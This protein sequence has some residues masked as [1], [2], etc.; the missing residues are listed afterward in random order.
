MSP[1]IALIGFGEAGRTFAAAGEWRAT[2]RVFDIKTLD[3]ATAPAMRA[4]YAAHGVIGCETLAQALDGADIVLSLV[5]ADQAAPAAQAAAR[6]IPPGALFCDL[7][8]VSPGTKTRNA[9]VLEAAGGRYV[10]VAVMSPVQPAALTA[11]LLVSGP[12]G[13]D[14]AAMLRSI[15]FSKVQPCGP[16]IG[17]ASATK[18]VRSV[19]VKGIE[20]LTA[21]M[22]LAARAAGVTDGVLR[23]LG[24]DWPQ[25]ADYNLDRMLAH[26]TRRAAEMEEVVATLTE[27]GIDPLMTRGTVARQRA[28]GTLLAGAD[29]PQDLEAKLAL[30]DE[31]H[32]ERTSNP[33]GRSA[34]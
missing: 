21:E 10:D 27:L 12:H 20:A 8:S 17:A 18:M 30:L 24:G 3:P 1:R 4:A 15:G 11:P 34:A 28:M 25:K 9:A 32:P 7:N 23:S 33:A 16:S 5:T 13:D 26:G 2:V 6:D 31:R 14:G 19:M 22:L 29:M